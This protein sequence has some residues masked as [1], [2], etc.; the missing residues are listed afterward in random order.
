M[1]SR[2]IYDRQSVPVIH[3]SKQRRRKIQSRSLPKVI[4]LQN[5]VNDTIDHSRPS[6]NSL[7]I[8]T[9]VSDHNSLP[10]T[11]SRTN[12]KKSIDSLLTINSARS[13]SKKR[14]K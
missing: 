6:E 7:K 8:S 2:K 3:T 1:S 5:E 10:S 12:P 4:P 11:Q 14:E 13:S 9:N